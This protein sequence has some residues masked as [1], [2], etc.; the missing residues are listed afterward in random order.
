VVAAAALRDSAAEVVFAARKS[1]LWR[2]DMPALTVAAVPTS[3][4]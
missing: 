4:V 2:G 3:D 1:V